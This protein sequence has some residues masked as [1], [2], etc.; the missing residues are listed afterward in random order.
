MPTVVRARPTCRPQCGHARH[1]TDGWRDEFVRDGEARRR[2]A[3]AELARHV[4]AG[5]LIRVRRGIYARPL[6]PTLRPHELAEQ[7]YRRLIQSVHLTEQ[8]P[9]VFSHQSAAL[10]WRLPTIGAWPER[11]HITPGPSGGGRSTTLI[12]KHGVDAGSPSVVDGLV[13]TSLARTVVDVARSSPFR[14]AVCMADAALHG[15]RD[16]AGRTIR[17]P[18]RKEQLFDELAAAGRGRG[19]AR[20]RAVI[21]FA[22]GLSGSAGESCSR[23]GILLLGLPAPVLQQAF[24]DPRGLIGYADF[25][26]PRSNLIGEFDG[27]AKYEDPT[28]LR[29][30]SPAQALTDEKL[31]EDRL[32][33]TGPRVTRWGWGTALSLSRLRTHLREAGVA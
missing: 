10:V 9:P 31:R 14:V 8:S 3:R 32:R 20:A 12:T 13:V 30:R 4:R 5:S 19:V 6:D 26:W 29:G 24:H 11:V 21:E 33:A 2:G 16:A 22:D 28:F 17:P 7:R 18:A 23:V 25:W 15:L 27:A 1:M